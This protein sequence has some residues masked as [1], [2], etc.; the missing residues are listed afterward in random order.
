MR[1]VKIDGINIVINMDRVKYIGF[2]KPTESGTCGMYIDDKCVGR[3]ETVQEKD[4]IL[5]ALLLSN[6]MEVVEIDERG[7]VKNSKELWG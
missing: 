5:D 4:R 3:A 1:L 6:E 7:Y 2:S